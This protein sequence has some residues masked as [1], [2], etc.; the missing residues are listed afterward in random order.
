MRLTAN[1]ELDSSQIILPNN[2]AAT[3]EN[4][5]LYVGASGSY[6]ANNAQPLASLDPVASGSQSEFTEAG[7][8]NLGYSTDASNIFS[9]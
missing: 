1:I 6:P 3:Y 5:V 9:T 2:I 8:M 7:L 4:Q